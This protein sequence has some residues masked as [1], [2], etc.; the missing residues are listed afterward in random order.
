MTTSLLI[1]VPATIVDGDFDTVESDAIA[2]PARTC[3]LG[4]QVNYPDSVPAT[5]DLALQVSMDVDGPW[6]PLDTMDE[7]DLTAGAAFKTVSQ[8][9]AA[10]F[11]RVT[12]TNATEETTVVKLIAKVAVP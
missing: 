4:W 5:M 11:A 2:L 12:G 9:T 1:G 6:T 3:V 8:A 10:R 7:G